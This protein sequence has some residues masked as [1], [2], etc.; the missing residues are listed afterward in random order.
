MRPISKAHKNEVGYKVNLVPP[1]SALQRAATY[2]TLQKVSL[3]A[4]DL[5]PCMPPW[6]SAHR[7]ACSMHIG[8]GLKCVSCRKEVGVEWKRCKRQRRPPLGR[9]DFTRHHHSAQTFFLNTYQDDNRRSKISLGW[10]EI[11]FAQ[12]Y[13]KMAPTLSKLNLNKYIIIWLNHICTF[14]VF[15]TS[16]SQ[17]TTF[18]QLKSHVL[19]TLG[20]QRLTGAQI[21][22]KYSVWSNTA[23]ILHKY[24]TNA[25]PALHRFLSDLHLISLLWSHLGLCLSTILW[26][27][28][29]PSFLCTL[30]VQILS[31]VLCVP[32][33]SGLHTLYS[34][35]FALSCLC[36]TGHILCTSLH[37][38][39]LLLAGAVCAIVCTSL[40][41][42]H[43]AV[44][45]P[46]DIYCAHPC[47]ICTCCAGAVCAILCTSLHYLHLLL[48]GAVCAKDSLREKSRNCPNSWERP[49]HRIK[50]K[51][52]I[53]F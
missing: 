17:L 36:T 40:H 9:S 3:P 18:F 7:P 37:Y 21:L 51:W 45:A 23:R 49:I 19:H 26:M 33:L 34:L 2:R 20:A 52:I 10:A 46:L 29:L 41:Y 6:P 16:F 50:S 35:H 5:N 22:H 28:T 31:S 53:H 24:C 13:D 32:D 42:L 30:A 48:A 47:S 38:I 44:C 27:C 15:L 14:V 43:S 11:W 1:H 39:H 12:L 4:S 25:L 8:Q